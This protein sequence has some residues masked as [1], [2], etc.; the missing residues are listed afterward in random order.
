MV[1]ARTRLVLAL[2]VAINIIAFVDRQLPFVLAESIR[3]DLALSDTQIGLIGGLAFA[4]FYGAAILPLAALADRWSAKWVLV[5]CVALWSATTALGG[6]AANFWQL[7]ASRMGVAIGEAASTPASHVMIAQSWP[8]ER[9]SMALGIFATGVPIGI[10]LGLGLGGWLNDLANWRVALVLI[11]LPGLIVAA[12][13]AI[14]APNRRS[15]ARHDAADSAGLVASARELF[16]C[17]SY[18][19]LAAGVTVF[20]VGGYAVFAFSAPFLIRVQGLSATQAGLALG[21]LHGV[22]GIIGALGGGVAADWLARR[23]RR[24]PLYLAGGGFAITAP[25][26]LAAWLAQSATLSLACLVVPALTGSL[27]SAPCFGA[28]QAL[29]PPHARAA[30]SAI[31]LLGQSLIGASLG[32]VLVGAISDRLAP[33]HGVDSLRYAL[34]WLA[35]GY[36][37]AGALV[38]AAAAHLRRDLAAREGAG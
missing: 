18:A 15:G 20:G 32:P 16:A 22:A 13:F 11:G 25:L 14:V 19:F 2:L 4:L 24:Y 9:R 5:G 28:A 35:L 31:P 36:A 21:L 1:S 27:Y 6:L 23:D 12:A 29:A 3:R 33:E 8:A 38:L 34:C 26:L 30:A 7:A 10:M 37:V 17:P